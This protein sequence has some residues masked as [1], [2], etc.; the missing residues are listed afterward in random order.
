MS[1]NFVGVGTQLRL[2]QITDILGLEF[3]MM[4]LLESELYE[5]RLHYNLET[6]LSLK[7]TST[8]TS[9][10]RMGK[11]VLQGQQLVQAL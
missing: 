9:G 7:C 11:L 5:L 8:G 10:L 1:L 2:F 3:G 4:E 6:P